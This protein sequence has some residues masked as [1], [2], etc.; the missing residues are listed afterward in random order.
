MFTYSSAVPSGTAVSAI[1][2]PF[3]GTNDTHWTWNSHTQQWLLSYGSTPATVE[4]GGQIATTNIVVQT[5]ASP[6]A[7]GS[8][9]MRAGSRCSPR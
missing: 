7:R 6:T 2:I 9:T 1:H 8:R 3:S 5:V 4:G